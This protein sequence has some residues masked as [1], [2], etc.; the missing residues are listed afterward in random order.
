MEGGEG[1]CFEMEGLN[2]KERWITAEINE[3]LSLLTTISRPFC[4]KDGDSTVSL[5]SSQ[6]TLLCY[7]ASKEELK[8]ALIELCDGIEEGPHELQKHI[9]WLL[10]NISIDLGG[11]EFISQ[12]LLPRFQH[13]REITFQTSKRMLMLASNLCYHT[14]EKHKHIRQMIGRILV[15]CSPPP[16]DPVA[17]KCY[18]NVLMAMKMCEQFE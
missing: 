18:Q 11:A 1:K 6:N 12:A 8:D 10:V 16:E 4:I 7:V 13:L 15:L 2:A 9:M 5:G 3:M 14:L 17:S